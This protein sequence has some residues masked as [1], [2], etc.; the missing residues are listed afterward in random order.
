VPI[1]TDQRPLNTNAATDIG[2]DSSCKVATGGA[3]NWV[4]VWESSDDLEGTIGSDLDILVSRSSD[5]GINWTTPVPLNSDAL[6]DNDPLNGSSDFQA[7]VISDGQ[8][9]WLAVWVKSEVISIEPYH[10]IDYDIFFARST[11]NGASWTAAAPLN[12]DALSDNDP[13]LDDFSP[14]VITDGQGHWLAAWTKYDYNGSQEDYDIFF[15]RSTDSG[16][17]WTAPAP[18]NTNAN[19]DTGDDTR[20]I[21]ARGVELATDRQGHWIAVWESAENLGGSAGIDTDLFVARSTDNGAT[22]SP[23][24]TLN[25]NAASDH[26]GVDPNNGGAYDMQPSVATDGHG[27]WIAA[28]ASNTDL[29]GTG[30]DSDILV[31]RSFNNGETWTAPVPLNT[32][33]YSDVAYDGEMSGTAVGGA[34]LA[35]DGQ[36]VWLAIW[37]SAGDSAHPTGYDYDILM[38]HSTDSGATWSD[39]V[40]LNSNAETDVERDEQPELATD[41]MGHWI[42]LWT[43]S[44]PT[45][46]DIMLATSEELAAAQDWELYQ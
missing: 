9:H 14:N 21:V 7:T 39:P 44:G 6:T 8:G 29:G 42:A 13:P 26:F 30:L 4:A 40:S 38:A 45:D 17:T 43:N 19:T 33:A 24:A 37:P 18:L 16:A 34:S 32:N 3:G 20:Y 5:N 25:T 46:G 11:D 10:I 22:W 36:G 2:G 31:A 23:P 1:F 27:N 12:T 15:A 28:W 41:G 35:T